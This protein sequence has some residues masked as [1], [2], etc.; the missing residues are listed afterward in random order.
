MT[1][2][3]P[4]AFHGGKARIGN[5]NV[6]AG[7]DIIVRTKIRPSF[8]DLGQP[9]LV[10]NSFGSLKG[11]Y[12]KR[13]VNRRKVRVKKNLVIKAFCNLMRDHGTARLT[14]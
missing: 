5:K 1:H 4:S 6:D 8:I 11:E 12:N 10:F 13:V 2:R 3:H 14:K 7:G 9:K